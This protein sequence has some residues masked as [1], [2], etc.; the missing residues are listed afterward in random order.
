MTDAA[1][2]NTDIIVAGAGSAG[3]SAAIALAQA[4]FD[5]ICAGKIPAH[6]PGRTVALFDGSLRFYKALG[7]WSRFAAETAP[8][9]KIRLVDDTGSLFRLPPVEFSAREI[10][11]DAFGEN[12]ENDVLVAGLA[13]IARAT[14]RL[15]L[16]ESLIAGVAPEADAIAVTLDDGRRVA[17]RLVVA[18]D[19]RKSIARDA[20]GIDV[21]AW[22]YPQTALTVLL[23][24]DQPHRDVSTEFH[25]RSGPCTLV[26]MVG[27]PGAPHR[28]SLVWLMS[29]REAERRMALSDAALAAE[30]EKQIHFIHGPTRVSGPRGAF[31]MGGLK[32]KAFAA[33]RIALIAE[34]AH[35][36]PP[37]GAQ[38]LNLS[39]RDIAT[40]VE[41]VEDARDEGRDI[42]GGETLGAY[43]KG[44]R[45]DVTTRVRGVDALNRSLLADVVPVD[46]LRGAGLIALAN[47]GPLR[48][49]LMR[50][51]VMPRGRPPRLMRA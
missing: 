7:L 42:G 50:E 33:R 46:F 30:I 41:T 24:H 34:T 22:P 15:T 9:E 2:I 48:R 27:R 12:I 35:V 26:P 17:G 3:L 44:R 31:P 11:L 32:A 1:E 18:A 37:I 29:P 23:E 8:L 28:S 47:L 39:L 6:A 45:A 4:G 36:F 5:V 49:A 16:I 25:T 43:D 20:A 38:G 14:P 21:E 51:G 19:G 13:E 10:G 40:L